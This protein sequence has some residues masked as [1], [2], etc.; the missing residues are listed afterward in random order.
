M[1]EYIEPMFSVPIFHLYAAD[2]E[3]KKEKLIEIASR[4]NFERKEGEYCPSD[5][6]DEQ[7]SYWYELQPLITP[8]IQRFVDRTGENFMVDRFWFERGGPGQ[9]HLVHNHGATGYSAVMYIEFDEEEHEPT[10]FICPFNEFTQ[11]LQQ[12]YVPRDIKS[13]SV[14]FFPS[15]I[16]HYTVPSQSEKPRL[17]LSWNLAYSKVIQF[18]DTLPSVDILQPTPIDQT[19]LPTQKPRI[20]LNY[21]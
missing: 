13:G 8:E 11:G 17:I 5:Y 10:H 1:A 19:E 20:K 12:S 7:Q 18:A 9:C 15:A 3:E 6:Y 2:W 21:V 4:A 14:I 16:H